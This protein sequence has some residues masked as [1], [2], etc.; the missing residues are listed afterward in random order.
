MARLFFSA[1]GIA[2]LIDDAI[3]LRYEKNNFAGFAVFHIELICIGLQHGH[4]R[5]GND[6]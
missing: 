2:R 4:A 1:G 3:S 5:M 6:I